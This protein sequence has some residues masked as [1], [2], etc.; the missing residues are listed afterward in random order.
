MHDLPLFWSSGNGLSGSATLFSLFL[1]WPF[2][3]T[4]PAFHTSPD[5]ISSAQP[6]LKWLPKNPQHFCVRC[7]RVGHVAS[8]CSASPRC[9][10]CWAY[11]HAVVGCKRLRFSRLTVWIPK[12]PIKQSNRPLD[13]SYSSSSCSS[14]VLCSSKKMVNFPVNP[15]AFLPHGMTM[16]QGPPGRKARVD[17]ALSGH[18]H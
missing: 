3:Q 2:P 6:N 11:G 9:Q 14:L 17:M 13:V 18:R 8:I 5:K 15:L 1:V 12:A 10:Y 4:M 7:L 16:E